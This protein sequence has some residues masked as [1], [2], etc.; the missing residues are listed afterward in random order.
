MIVK[1]GVF[2]KLACK[3]QGEYN[4]EIK[5]NRFNRKHTNSKHIKN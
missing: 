5:C 3:R 4:N 2:T 1:Q